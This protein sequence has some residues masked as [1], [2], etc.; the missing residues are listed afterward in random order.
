MSSA[1]LSRTVLANLVI[2]LA[3]KTPNDYRSTNLRVLCIATGIGRSVG[4]VELRK[5][6]QLTAQP[7]TSP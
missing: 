6:M 3:A 4:P 1:A 7:N 5:G 2:F